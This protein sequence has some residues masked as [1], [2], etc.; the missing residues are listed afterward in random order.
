MFVDKWNPVFKPEDG[1]GAAEPAPVDTT[2]APAATP[3]AEPGPGSGRTPLR[4]QLEKNFAAD[5][6]RDA[7]ETRERGDDGKFQRA[8]GHKVG[9][10]PPAEA[11]PAPDAPAAP[12]EAVA[13]EAPQGEAPP[14]ETPASAPPAG[15]ADDAKAA[16]AALPPQVQAAVAK[17]EQDMAKGVEDLKGRYADIDKAIAPHVEA[18]RRHGHT[19]AQAV[20]QLFSWFQA[21][22]ANPGQA[23]PA[24]A[25][26][27]GID[28][29][30]FGQQQGQPQPD[31]AAP[32]AGQPAPDE[33]LS[34]MMQR[35]IGG[36]QQELGQLKQA[37]S[38]QIGGLQ[39]TFAEQSQ[40]KT[41]ETLAV[42]AKDKPY[43]EEVRELM[44]HLIHSQAVPLKEGG[45]VDLD[46]A[47]DQAIW[48]RPEVRQRIL[49]DQQK[50]QQDAAKAKA[51][52]ERKAQQEQAAKAARAG[53]SL[54]I[55]APGAPAQPDKG[56]Q[57]KGKSV[58]ESINEAIAAA[59]EQ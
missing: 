12:A 6:E 3:E 28:I 7:K 18:I 44:A 30:A 22:A 47:Y 36:L 38:E 26:S 14:A 57:T 42:W 15:W 34:P 25:Q 5:R 23:F 43:F 20:N 45:K 27:F 48:A 11:E 19:P 59:N 2:P 24:L 46:T 16:W 39:N 35:Y 55:G 17:R 49:A 13:G 41:E 21:L 32:A 37:F 9:D 53:S 10:R 58:R 4:Q 40:A 50:K 51:E 29:R 54:G 52:A 1:T 56:K 33:Q 8:K 31:P